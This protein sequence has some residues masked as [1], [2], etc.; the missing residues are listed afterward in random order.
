MQK[1]YKKPDFTDESSNVVIS[2]GDFYALQMMTDI[3][4]HSVE[5]FEMTAKHIKMTVDVIADQN[6][7]EPINEV[8]ENRDR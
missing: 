7:V 2:I 4:S 3:L 8:F 5:N 1:Q 6:G